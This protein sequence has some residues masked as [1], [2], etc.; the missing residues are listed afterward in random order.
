M[1]LA[2][3]NEGNTMKM[4]KVLCT[5]CFAVLCFAD[6][7][8][9]SLNGRIQM[10]ATNISGIVIAVVILCLCNQK[11]I[12]KKI[13]CIWTVICFIFIPLG[14]FGTLRI[15]PYKG[16]VISA[17]I[18]IWLYG[19][20]IVR[21]LRDKHNTNNCKLYSKVVLGGWLL[22]LLFMQLSVNKNIWPLWFFIVFG[23]FYMIEL[24]EKILLP[25]IFNGIIVGFFALQGAALL[26]RP[27]DSPRYMG[28]YINSNFNALFY[29]MAFSAFLCRWYFQIKFH[30]SLVIKCFCVFFSSILVGF[31]F[32]TGSKASIFAMM[33][34]LIMFLVLVKKSE[35]YNWAWAIKK[36]LLVAV[37]AVVS[38]PVIYLAIRYIP[39]IHLHPMYFEGEYNERKVQPGEPRDSEKYI[40]FEYSMKVNAGRLFYMFPDFL[41]YWNS[42]FSLTVHAMENTTSEEPIYIFTSEEVKRG[43]DPLRLRVEIYK[44][45]VKK[46]NF[47]GHDN[48]YTGA[49][50][51]EGYYAPHAHNVFIQM[52]FLYGIPAGFLF[53]L[54]CISFIPAC[55]TY[56]KNGNAFIPIIIVCFVT[57]FLAFGFFEIDWMCGQLPFTLFFVLFRFVV[58]APVSR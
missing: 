31:C 30:S 48:D 58:R 32:F 57:S 18:N 44:Y 10:T 36:F 54:M 38:V 19:Y 33:V 47:C 14:V 42:K 22:M 34:V 41:D 13:T 29:L 16:Q 2:L 28:M 4:Q 1:H 46:L 25:S 17:A 49:P 21:V 5:F 8:K 3:K 43:I 56:F 12:D 20:I 51:M 55:L 9:G 15:I 6:W 39:T 45:Y 35:N 52:A 37:I 27:Y 26:F 24:N 11:K 53:M 7:A 40:S 50:I 23:S